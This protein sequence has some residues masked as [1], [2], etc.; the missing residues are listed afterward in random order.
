MSAM[1]ASHAELVLG[2]MRDPGTYPHLAGAVEVSETHSA[3]VFLAGDRAYKVKKAVE[4]SFLDYG[5]LARRRELCR[6][7]VRLNRRLARRIYLGT[8]ALVRAERG[9]ALVPDGGP[10]RDDALEVAVEMRRFAPQDTLAWR[11]RAGTATDEDAE[12]I[13]HLLAGFHL[14][15]RRPRHVHAAT[16]ALAD[17]IH[18]TLDDLDGSPHAAIEPRRLRALRRFLDALLRGRSAELAHRAA[19]GLVRDGHGDLRA[20]HVVLG[21]PPQVVDCLEFDPALRVGDVALD[22]AFLVM[23]L[24]ALGAP[25]LA[26]RIVTAY[27][28]AGGEPGD[29]RLLAG[30]ACFRALVRAKVAAVRVG[31]DGDD[32]AAATAELARLVALAESFAWRARGP[33]VIVC[34]GPAASGKT[35]LA[36][37]LARAGNVPHISSDLTRKHL[38]GVA[39]TSRAP[40]GAYAPAVTAE[41]YAR[42]AAQTIDAIQGDGGAVVDATFHTAASRT[43]YLDAL[44]PCR[45]EV[46]FVECRAPVEVLERRAAERARDPDRVSDA[47]A[48]VMRRQ[49]AAWDPFGGGRGRRHLVVPADQPVEAMVDA[50]H[51]WLDR[52]LEDEAPRTRRPS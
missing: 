12:R 42:L 51:A 25:G 15:A 50:V 31:Q 11:V 22:L 5:T 32:A 4:L 27:R 45:A 35:T 41:T 38:V 30:L 39:P 14:T 3:W 1:A 52:R 21:D 49:L 36:R 29:D 48:D 26:A 6:E 18:A 19:R 40:A 44:G 24:E 33:L 9:F 34:C 43:A 13:G 7:E 16:T 20:E 47:T 10:G 8:V 28:H 23:D 37:E 46:L 17:A 2:A